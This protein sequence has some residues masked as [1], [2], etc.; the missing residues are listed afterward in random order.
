[1]A[2]GTRT[3]ATI[4][5]TIVDSEWSSI[6]LLDA[7]WYSNFRFNSLSARMRRLTRS[8]CV[9]HT[10]CWT[11]TWLV[12]SLR[13]NFIS[14]PSSGESLQLCVER[15]WRGDQAFVFVGLNEFMLSNGWF[16]FY[17]DLLL[18]YCVGTLFCSDSIHHRIYCRNEREWQSAR[19]ENCLF[20]NCDFAW[21]IQFWRKGLSFHR[22]RPS[23]QKIFFIL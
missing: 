21:M 14:S 8:L 18:V 17:W 22:F 4:T 13:G 11:T 16:V 19:E 10:F 20:Q 9:S 15:F 5:M 12:C 23:I 2:V 7:C 1:M 6:S 3:V